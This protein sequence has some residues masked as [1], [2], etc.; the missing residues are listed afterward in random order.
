[1]LRNVTTERL[2]LKKL[3]TGDHAFIHELVNTKGW[4]QFIGNRNIS[5]QEDAIAYINKINNTPN[6]TYW[7]AR[8]KQSDE[9]IGI[10][11]FIKRPF[12]EHF[13]IGFAFLPQYSGNGYAYEGAREILSMVSQQA[14]HETVLATTIPDNINSIKLLTKLGLH[15]EK[16]IEVDNNK[17]LLY[18]YHANV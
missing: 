18:A 17:L 15:F 2:S 11:T 1:M 12:L 16:E 10:I 4:L 7:V 9:P 8:L 14:K 3:T 6:L 13:D 5:S